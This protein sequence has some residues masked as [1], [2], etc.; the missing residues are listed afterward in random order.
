MHKDT[1]SFA[2]SPE[3]MIVPLQTVLD[4]RQSFIDWTVRL[5]EG[6]QHSGFEVGA[7]QDIFFQLLAACTGRSVE[8][9]AEGSTLIQRES[10]TG[11]IPINQGE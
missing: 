10:P 8:D 1:I 9:L 2:W 3:Q 11:S 6:G 4:R 7:L 5:L